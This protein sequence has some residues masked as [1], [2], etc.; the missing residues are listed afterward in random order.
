MLELEPLVAPAGPQVSP[1]ARTGIRV[2]LPLLRRSIRWLALVCLTVFFMK[3]F[4][5]DASLV[6]TA[7]ME[8][9]ILVGDHL[10]LNKIL[11]GPEIPLG[12]WRLPMLKTIRRGEIV[13]FH[14]PKD[15][16][17]IFLKRVAAVAGDRIEIREA[18]LYVN[19]QAVL[20]PYTVHR[21]SRSLPHEQ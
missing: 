10:F 5:G 3:I 19:S 13:A 17:Q 14:Y 2:R 16:A 9:T 20:E 6:P 12:H 11:Y 4:V 21:G 1:C 7:S 8:G 18:V 15:P